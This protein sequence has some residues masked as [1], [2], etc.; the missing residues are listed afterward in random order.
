[1][2]VTKEVISCDNIH[3]TYLLGAEGVPAVRGVDVDVHNGEL[4]IIYGTSGGGKSTLLNLLGTIDLPSKGNLYLFGQR[5]TD[6]TPDSYLASMRCQR[7]GFVFQSFNLLST[8]SAIDNVSLPML[9][10]G[11]LSTRE[12]RKRAR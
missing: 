4:L 3:K 9:I 2:N 5:I 7:I 6:Q 12:I 10:N 8:M 11:K 1:M